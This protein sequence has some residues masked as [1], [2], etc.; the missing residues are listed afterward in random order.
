MAAK[1]TADRIVGRRVLNAKY[2][3]AQSGKTKVLFPAFEEARPGGVSLDCLHFEKSNPTRRAAVFA[4]AR[5]VAQSEG[6]NV[7]GWATVLTRTAIADQAVSEIVHSPSGSN[8]GHAD[9]IPHVLYVI[10][11]ADPM[12]RDKARFLAKFLAELCFEHGEYAV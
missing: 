2:L 4:R 8:P 3:L 10:G 6:H 11:P 9:L 7:V 12:A 5:S 1:V